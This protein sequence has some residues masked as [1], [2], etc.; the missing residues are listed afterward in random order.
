MRILIFILLLIPCFLFSQTITV[1]IY[2]PNG[3]SNPLPKINVYRGNMNNMIATGQVNSSGIYIFNYPAV[4]TTY[5]FEPYFDSIPNTLITTTDVNDILRESLLIDAPNNI[6]GVHLNKGY[7][8]HAADVK[9][10]KRLDA[11][12]AYMVAT[13]RYL[14]NINKTF[15]TNIQLLCNGGFE[16]MSVGNGN[17][18]IF[19]TIPCWT[20]TSEFEIWGNGML[21]IPAYEG[22]TFSE[23]NA[24]GAQTN[25]QNFTVQPNDT[26]TISFA[27][28]AR[29]GTETVRLGIQ[30]VG[31][32]TTILRTS[33]L[34]P[35]NGWRNYSMTF[36]IPPVISTNQY[37]LSISTSD[38]GG[39][40]NL[41]DGF[42][43]IAKRYTYVSYFGADVLWFTKT[44]FDAMTPNNWASY[45]SASN[46]M[47]SVANENKNIELKYIIRGNNTISSQ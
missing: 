17:Y 7:K 6:R 27:H 47:V 24:Y 11:G 30:A 40:G 2:L 3:W 9:E 13:K 22:S 8:F 34:V 45:S 31:E 44:N 37:R 35:S 5:Y 10:T 33:T 20:S 42:S 32:S 36:V 1:K 39:V 14:K 12:Q 41:I 38:A 21:G 19:S 46:F 25:F 29:T 26:L 4:N 43:V 15:L 16:S 18:S 28:R 23:L